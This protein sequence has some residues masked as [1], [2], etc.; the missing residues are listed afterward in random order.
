MPSRQGS[1]AR[2]LIDERDGRLAKDLDAAIGWYNGKTAKLI[3]QTIRNGRVPHVDDV[4]RIAAALQT[5]TDPVELLIAFARDAGLR[6][7]GENLGRALT[8]IAQTR[9]LTHA[10]RATVQQVTDQIVA[11]FN[12]SR[13]ARRRRR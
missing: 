5:P 10:E 12:A 4:T 11:Q 8:L 1:F 2:S 6:T 7:S 9:R 13:A 3:A